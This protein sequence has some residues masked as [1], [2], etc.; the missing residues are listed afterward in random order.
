[1][2]AVSVFRCTVAHASQVA[3]GKQMSEL[4]QPTTATMVAYLATVSIRAQARKMIRVSLATS[5][6]NA[7]DDE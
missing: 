4:S 6:L 5:C 2:V 7:K 1:M 3:K